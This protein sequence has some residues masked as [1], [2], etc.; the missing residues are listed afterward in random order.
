MIT[1]VEKKESNK[2]AIAVNLIDWPDWCGLVNKHIHVLTSRY[3]RYKQGTSSLKKYYDF[4]IDRSNFQLESWKS[5]LYEELTGAATL[6]LCSSG[7]VW[8]RKCLSGMV[9]KCQLVCLRNP[10]ILRLI[11]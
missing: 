10:S 3:K 2:A 8:A 1:S 11:S 4:I 7:A 6:R 9:P 5:V